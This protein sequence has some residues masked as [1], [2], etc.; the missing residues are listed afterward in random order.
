MHSKSMQKLQ[1][2][3]YCK[4]YNIKF[5][6]IVSLLW[7]ST[8]VLSYYVLVIKIVK[9]KKN[10]TCSSLYSNNNNYCKIHLQCPIPLVLIFSYS[11]SI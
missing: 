7:N 5:A 3:T 8:V 10:F 11:I 6:I 9:L 2:M 4:L 1:N